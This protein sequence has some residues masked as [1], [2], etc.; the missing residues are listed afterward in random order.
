MGTAHLLEAV[1]SVDSVQAIVIITT[2]KVYENKEWAHPYRE[3]D[4][5]GGYDPY[6]A[7]KAASEII[8]SS[9]RMSFT[10][11]LATARAGNVIGG[12]DWSKDRLVPDCLRALGKGEPVHLRYPEAVRP[13]QHVLDVLKG[14]LLLAENLVESAGYACAW[15]FGPSD[16]T[17]VGSVAQTLGRLWG[18][19]LRIDMGLA[20]WR[21]E[22]GL[23]QLDSSRARIE[24]GWA[25]KWSL[26]ESL[27]ATVAWHKLWLRSMDMQKVS[28]LQI[29]EY[30]A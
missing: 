25:P 11:R 28:L 29:K 8:A 22:T 26:E 14:Y 18:T 16:A 2:D 30:E 10:L 19:P 7:S 12:G 5:L 27:K 1:R 13:W 17:T 20:D 23:L 3:S 6:S 21:H 15:N 4:R 24:L 9:F